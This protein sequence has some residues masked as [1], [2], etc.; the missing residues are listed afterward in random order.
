MLFCDLRSLQE[1]HSFDFASRRHSLS[2]GTKA[3]GTP[4]TP[5]ARIGYHLS[6]FGHLNPDITAIFSTSGSR[7]PLQGAGVFVALLLQRTSSVTSTK[8]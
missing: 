1:Q 3:T 7:G 8:V 6:F 5:R 4:T 2:G